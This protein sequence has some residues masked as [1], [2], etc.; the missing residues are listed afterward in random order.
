MKA[1]FLLQPHASRVGVRTESTRPERSV[2]V[3]IYKLAVVV[4]GKTRI[5]TE[6]EMPIKIFE[7][8]VDFLHK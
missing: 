1:R 7:R 3:D 8:I 2:V 4:Q 5:L 6:A